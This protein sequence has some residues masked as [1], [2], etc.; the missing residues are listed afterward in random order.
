MNKKRNRKYKINLKR[1]TLNV[2]IL[3]A[4]FMIYN[5][6]TSNIF[7]KKELKTRE[8]TVASQDTLWNI[9]SKIC[10]DNS[11]LNIQEVINDIKEINGLENCNI[12]AGD[13][14]AIPVYD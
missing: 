3:L 5:I 11:S 4:I 12:V 1:V 9:S 14:L 7:G 6:F 13:I 8:L 10:K 2:I